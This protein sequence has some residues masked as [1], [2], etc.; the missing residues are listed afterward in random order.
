MLF[1]SFTQFF[2]RRTEVARK[3][4]GTIPKDIVMYKSKLK[5]IEK[6]IR[7]LRLTTRQDLLAAS[8]LSFYKT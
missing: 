3:N 1:G 5:L 2:R 6:G 4:F 7:N 8:L